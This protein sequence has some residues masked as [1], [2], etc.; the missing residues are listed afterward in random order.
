MYMKVIH[1]SN[2]LNYIIIQVCLKNLSLSLSLSF[3][4]LLT[5]THTHTH[6]KG[7]SVGT[8]LQLTTKLEHRRHCQQSH[9]THVQ[10]C[11]QTYHVRMYTDFINRHR[12]MAHTLTKG[13]GPRL[14][15]NKQREDFVPRLL[16][17]PSTGQA[18]FKIIYMY[19]TCRW[20]EGSRGAR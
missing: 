1:R 17:M 11:V 20:W 8:R 12:L 4:P 19:C 3:S 13:G 18:F 16:S 2:D 5:D 15:E 10:G 14:P 7:P 9:S 6:T